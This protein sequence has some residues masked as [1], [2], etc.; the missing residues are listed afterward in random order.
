MDLAVGAVPDELRESTKGA[1]D[2]RPTLELQRDL[3]GAPDQA[4]R[5]AK[6]RVGE[7]RFGQ[8]PEHVDQ[9][10]IVL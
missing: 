10:R 2:E 4:P 8:V 1:D 7:V 6:V 3:E 9:Q 5:T